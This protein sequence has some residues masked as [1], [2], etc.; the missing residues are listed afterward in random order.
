LYRSWAGCGRAGGFQSPW[1]NEFAIFGKLSLGFSLARPICRKMESMSGQQPEWHARR[2]RGAAQT[3]QAD[4]VPL[5]QLIDL[6]GKSAQGGL[7]TLLAVPCLIPSLGI[8]W[9]ISL[10]FFAI[11]LVMLRGGRTVQLPDRLASLTLSR[12]TAQRLLQALARV[13]GM[14]QGLARPRLKGLTGSTA[15]RWLSVKVFLMALIIFL[16]IPA[17]NTLPAISL[18]LLGPALVFRDGAL[19]IASLVA[20]VVAVV[21]TAGLVAGLVWG[22]T[23][24]L[25]LVS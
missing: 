7:L 18:L 13:Y 19:V 6:Q 1:L 14:A 22:T 10:G 25:A 3:L 5:R 16:P 2:L 20:A 15:R 21:G 8:G 17:G 24:G 9:V 11:G 23:Q 4:V 12:T